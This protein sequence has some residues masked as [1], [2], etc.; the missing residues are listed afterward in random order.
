MGNE[1]LNK[2]DRKAE[3]Q[4]RVNL[5]DTNSNGTLE[6]SELIAV[7][8]AHAGEFL[9]FCDGDS[10]G[11][12]TADEFSD[13]IQKD[14]AEM[15]DED[16]QINWL[17]RMSESITAAT[18]AAG[19]LKNKAFLFIKPHAVTEATKTL[20]G[21]QLVEKGF[22]ICSEGSISAEDI[23]SKQLIDNHY[24]AIAS[25]ATILKPAE[26]NIPEDKFQTKFGLS[27]ADA[28]AGGRVF[29]ALDA[30]ADLEI[31]PVEMDRQWGIHKKADK[32]IK[33]GGGF[34]CGHLE[35]EGKEPCYV[36]NGF[37]MEM[38]NKYVAK[39][40][41]IHYYVVEWDP[42]VMSWEDFR[43]KALGPT[44]PEQ[45]P[46]DSIRGMIYAKWEEL[47]L[48]AKPD[49]GD[50]GMHGSA[51]PFEALAELLNWTGSA[52]EKEPFGAAMLS[53]GIGSEAILKWSKDAQVKLPETDGM[54]SVFDACEDLNAAECLATLVAIN[55]KECPEA[56]TEAPAPAE[57]E[58]AVPAEAEP[59]AP[60]EAP[61]LT[62]AP[63]PAPK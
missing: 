28:L 58:Q 2:M 5:I 63:A 25:K 60:A 9:S 10:D 13:G 30:C 17:D 35:I 32:L 16:F 45:A 31:D 61:A 48:K 6:K 29:N 57:A 43:G 53:A 47:G 22:T 39:G 42:A 37:F 12:L 24:Y 15:S 23:D 56:R 44:D 3:L 8:G 51:S 62:E 40:L 36:F 20:V 41:S 46:A 21:A 1:P 27:W 11:A 49:V 55:K 52:V 14:T 38:R 50:N 18:P 54:G 26:L 19:A 33:F 7:F 34:Y 59:V 4:A